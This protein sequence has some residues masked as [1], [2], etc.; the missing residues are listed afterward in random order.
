MAEWISV[1]DRL[2]KDEM[3]F[4][5]KY[6]VVIRTHGGALPKGYYEHIELATF[7]SAC[8]PDPELFH[9][10]NTAYWEFD[11]NEQSIPFE[12]THWMP[13]PEPPKDKK[14]G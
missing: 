11:G 8:E 7:M 4:C 9:E 1:E 2:P 14:N 6:L 10:G 13:L 3:S 12:V 5:T